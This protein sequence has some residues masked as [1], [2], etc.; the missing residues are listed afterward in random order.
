MTTWQ[1]MLSFVG[2]VPSGVCAA[3]MVANITLTVATGRVAQRRI[4]RAGERAAHPER[5]APASLRRDTALTLA[6]LVPAALFWGMILAGS[7]R[8]LVAFGQT[9]LD[10]NGGA[11]YLVPGTLDGVSITFAFLAFRAVHKRR[12][13]SRC[14]RVVWA[15]SLSSATV[16]FAYEYS[17]THHNVIT[18]IYLALLSC[19]ARRVVAAQPRHNV[20]NAGQRRG[21]VR[22]RVARPELRPTR[23]APPPVSPVMAS[24]LCSVV[25]ISVMR[26]RAR[27]S[28]QRTRRDAQK[29]F[30]ASLSRRPAASVAPYTTSGRIRTN[31]KLCRYLPC[32]KAGSAC[33]S[34][35]SSGV[36]GR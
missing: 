23:P 2:R 34:T 6:S 13:P 21:C 18:G 3:L 30:E 7:F 14:F 19:R 32:S 9:V 16:N 28:R 36:T 20:G 1:E 15:A 17:Y 25:L 29:A 26:P 35:T 12:D 27:T 11:E 24:S 10:W 4:R 5:F 31:F 22:R 8:G 33:T